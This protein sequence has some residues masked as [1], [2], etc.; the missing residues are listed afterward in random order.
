MISL[1]KSRLDGADADLSHRA[2]FK[3]RQG[4]TDRR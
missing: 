1:Q 3:R 4:E 2:D